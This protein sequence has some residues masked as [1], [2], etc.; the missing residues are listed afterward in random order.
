MDNNI[1]QSTMQ[2]EVDPGGWGAT[3]P[4]SEQG[5]LHSA[6]LAINSSK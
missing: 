3:P 6:L 2:R 5:G 1:V 4:A